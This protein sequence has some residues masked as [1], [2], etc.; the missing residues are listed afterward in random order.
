[1]T[2]IEDLLRAEP[3]QRAYDVTWDPDLARRVPTGTSPRRP[4]RL[5]R[6]LLVAAAVVAVISAAAVVLRAGPGAVHARPEPSAT[7]LSSVPAALP[8]G[9]D[10]P[11]SSSVPTSRPF[12]TGAASGPRPQFSPGRVP[13]TG[14]PTT[15]RLPYQQGCA[16]MPT[17]H[18]ATAAGDGLD[19]IPSP[20]PTNPQGSVEHAPTPDVEAV[21]ADLEEVIDGHRF[22]G[23]TVDRS[24]TSI[25]VY[26]VRGST[27]ADA[28]AAAAS[29]ARPTVPITL[30]TATRSLDQ[31][32]G[33]NA[34]LDRSLPGSVVP[35][36][37]ISRWEIS[38]ERNR[39]TVTLE[40]DALTAQM[41][42]DLW[43]RYGDAV[44]VWLYRREVLAEPAAWWAG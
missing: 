35:F 39:V 15:Y 34:T 30:K 41:R 8:S 7:G 2:E 10:L 36:L 37:L 18:P 4:G 29:C 33:L 17:R 12:A 11:S 3:A 27:E 43:V 32:E 14:A 20:G 1:M 19:P 38:L 23:L 22:G 26:V 40:L 9:S 13:L 42:H 21:R 6:S 16:A 5:A 44:D 28:R 25:T 24:G 31:L